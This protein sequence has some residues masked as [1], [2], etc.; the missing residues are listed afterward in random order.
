MKNRQSLSAAIVATVKP[1][2]SL[3]PSAISAR[4]AEAME[5]GRIEHAAGVACRI[6]LRTFRIEYYREDTGEIVSSHI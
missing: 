4:E 1:L 3:Y 6:N 5:R 2:E